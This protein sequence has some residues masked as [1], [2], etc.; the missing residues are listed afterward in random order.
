[1]AVEVVPQ[2]QAIGAEV[3]GV[4]LSKDISQ[5]DFEQI[6][7]AFYRHSVIVVCDHAFDDED[8]IRFSSR[9]GELKRLKFNDFIGRGRPEIFIVSNVKESDKYIGSHDAGMFW[10]SDGPFLKHPHGPAALHA[11]EVPMHD[12]RALGDTR[13]ASTAAAYDALSLKFLPQK[14]EFSQ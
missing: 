14:P 7:Q 12:G 5:E 9:F 3:R 2:T 11:L 4:D 10:H 1:M 13:F 8:H 6:R